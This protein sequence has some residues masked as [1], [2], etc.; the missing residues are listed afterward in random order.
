MKKKAKVLLSAILK[1]KMSYV[2]EKNLSFSKTPI[3]TIKE[4][5]ELSNIVCNQSR[6]QKKK[7]MRQLDNLRQTYKTEKEASVLQKIKDAKQEM[8]RLKHMNT[9]HNLMYQQK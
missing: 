8:E 9:T 1:R 5:V 2:L 4:Y 6:K 7:T 3:D